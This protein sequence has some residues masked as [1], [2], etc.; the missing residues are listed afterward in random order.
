MTLYLS[1]RSRSVGGAVVD[2]R[3][4]EGDGTTSPLALSAVGATQ[5]AARAAGKNVLLGVHGFNVSYEHGACSLGQLEPHLDLT[6][7]DVFFGV[8][9][10][11]DSWLPIVN[12]PFEGDVS[13]DCGRRLAAFCRSVF[14]SAQSISFVSHSLGARLVV[15]AVKN[16]DRPARTVCLTA[17]A[18]NRDCLA[19]EYAAAAANSAAISILASRQDLVL[20]VAFRIGDPIADA[21][22]DDH[23]LFET[24][25]GS[26]GPPTPAAPPIVPPWQI[27]DQAGYGHGD[28]LPPG[29]RVQTPQEVAGARWSRSAGF[30]ARAFRGQPQTWP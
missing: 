10:P 26:A 24:A 13:M 28:Y 16:L 8:L 17:P 6:A 23:A 4:L 22:H 20:K 15:E 7:S 11:G 9:W 29:D 21:L 27:P 30:I 5:T 1:C 3:V 12:Y 18:I 2:P 19:T 25:L 14:A